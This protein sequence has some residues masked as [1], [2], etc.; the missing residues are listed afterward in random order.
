ML[1]AVLRSLEGQTVRWPFTTSIARRKRPF[2]PKGVNGR[3]PTIVTYPVGTLEIRRQGSLA[4]K[5]HELG[6]GF[7]VRVKY[8]SDSCAD[9]AHIGLTDDMALNARLST[10]LERN[11]D[12]VDD[13]VPAV[14]G[15]LA[16][17]RSSVAYEAARKAEVM[18]YGF[19]RDVYDKLPATAKE[20]DY[21]VRD[22]EAN[23]QLQSLADDH[24]GA[25]AAAQE[26]LHAVFRSRSTCLW[27]LFWV[28]LGL[29]C[30]ASSPLN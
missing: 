13:R 7:D 27:Y 14:L 15:L 25:F 20:I 6:S 18:T 23:G 1:R 17:F 21:R 11:G 12:L 3:S 19:L 4:W 5:D 30:A 22:L 10:F 16:D 29:L 2:A 9:A 26:R 28:R 8:G 24:A